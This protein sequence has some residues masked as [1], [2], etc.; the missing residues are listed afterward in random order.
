MPG[1]RQEWG[2]DARAKC[3]DNNL[4]LGKALFF[5]GALIRKPLIGKTHQSVKPSHAR[6]KSALP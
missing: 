6:G 5:G 1:G 3:I 2:I 4:C